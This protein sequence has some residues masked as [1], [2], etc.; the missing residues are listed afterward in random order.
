MNMTKIIRRWN[1]YRQTVQGTR[2]LSTIAPS[3]IS[4][5]SAGTSRPSPANTPRSSSASGWYYD[6]EYKPGAMVDMTQNRAP[7]MKPVP[8]GTIET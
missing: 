7:G 5:S 2:R 3:P 1:A 4:A 6:V 8:A